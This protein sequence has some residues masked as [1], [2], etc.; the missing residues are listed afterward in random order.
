MAGNIGQLL[1]ADTRGRYEV[2]EWLM[3]QMGGVGPMLVQAHHLRIYAP[4]RIP[5]AI[6]RYIN[7]ARRLYGVMDKCLANSR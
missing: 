4:A 6:E 1:P 7:E 5:Y 3:F 2:L